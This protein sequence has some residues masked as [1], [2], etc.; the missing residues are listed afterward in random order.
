M[1]LEALVSAGEI[2]TVVTSEMMSSVY[3]VQVALREIADLNRKVCVPCNI[4]KD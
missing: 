4:K 2:T 3:G 1:E